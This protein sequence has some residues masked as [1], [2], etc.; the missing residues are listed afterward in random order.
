M[1]VNDI[2]SPVRALY[3]QVTC[4][5]IPRDPPTGTQNPS[6]IHQR[7][8]ERAGS[9]DPYRVSS[10]GS[11][12]FHSQLPKCG[13]KLLHLF[14]KHVISLL[15]IFFRSLCIPHFDFYHCELFPLLIQFIMEIHHFCFQRQVPLL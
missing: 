7:Q 2:P 6:Q 15:S 9:L 14:L 10:L 13:E 12:G 8:R 4:H 1:S 3:S 11:P 5:P